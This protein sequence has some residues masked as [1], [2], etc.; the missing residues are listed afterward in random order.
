M[1]GCVEGIR[2]ALV[3]VLRPGTAIEYA[4]FID[5]LQPF[6][7]LFFTANV[8]SATTGLLATKSKHHALRSCTPN[9]GPTTKYPVCARNVTSRGVSYL[10]NHCSSWVH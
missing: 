8:F 4:P 5:P 10:S 7:P 3:L 2:R 9:P 6:L 1:M